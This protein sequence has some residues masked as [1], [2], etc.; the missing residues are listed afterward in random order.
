MYGY[1]SI[2]CFILCIVCFALAG[3]FS[4]KD[5]IDGADTKQKCDNVMKIDILSGITLKD[6]EECGIWHKDM[7]LKGKFD[8]KEGNC[9]SDSDVKPLIFLV[10]GV[11]FLAGC[12]LCMYLWNKY[13]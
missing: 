5:E 13:R 12:V 7:C 10:I 11:L 6:G 9:V 4:K 3:Y 8:L 2:V 1:T